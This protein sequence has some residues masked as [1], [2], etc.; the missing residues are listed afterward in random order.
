MPQVR[1]AFLIAIGRQEAAN[2]QE[3]V[4]ELRKSSAAYLRRRSS[5]GLAKVKDFNFKN[6]LHFTTNK[7][8]TNLEEVSECV[9]AQLSAAPVQVYNDCAIIF[10]GFDSC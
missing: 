8:N 6:T 2:R 9:C 7:G 10:T 1:K 4:Q 5:A 3:T